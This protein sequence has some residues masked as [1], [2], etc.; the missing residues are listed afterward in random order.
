MTSDILAF[1][2]ANPTRLLP[3]SFSLINSSL[4]PRYHASV[5]R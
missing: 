1:T 2:Y 4:V 5:P 3:I